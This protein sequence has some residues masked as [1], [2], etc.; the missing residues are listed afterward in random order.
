MK[1]NPGLKPS[2]LAKKAKEVWTALP[3]EEK[4]EWKA[5]AHGDASEAPAA[6]AEAPTESD[7]AAK[8]EV[9]SENDATASTDAPVKA[10][11]SSG[12]TQ[13]VDDTA[14]QDMESE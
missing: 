8:A 1:S 5:R 4:A 10:E 3:A 12:D 6:K 11:P 2:D 9:P 7:T 13:P 14:T